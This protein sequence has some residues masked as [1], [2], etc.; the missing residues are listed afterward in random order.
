MHCVLETPTFAKSAD[1]VGMSED[2]RH[3]L[4]T[5]LAENP[6]LGE[7][8]PGTGGARKLRFGTPHGGKR[9][10]YRVVTFFAAEDVPLFLLDI[11]RKGERIDLSK[12]ERN[13]LRKILKKVT[14]DY[15]AS[16]RAKIAH[17]SEKAS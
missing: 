14:E 5:M 15:R 2:E 7:L 12:A 9:S 1:D 17:L 6:T 16:V 3:Q 8:I 13:E 10:G 11:F 4:T